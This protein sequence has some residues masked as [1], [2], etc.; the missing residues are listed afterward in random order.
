MI[1]KNLEAHEQLEPMG[2]ITKK[3]RHVD[4]TTDDTAEYV[5]RYLIISYELFDRR[6][7]RCSTPITSEYLGELS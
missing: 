6:E 3:K 7:Q 4:C 1:D 5:T 2:S